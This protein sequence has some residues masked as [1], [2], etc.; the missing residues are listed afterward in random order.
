MLCCAYIDDLVVELQSSADVGN[1]ISDN[2]IVASCTTIGVSF[3]F[4]YCIIDILGRR[5]ES[6]ERAERE[7]VRV[8]TQQTCR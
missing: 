4:K 1:L 2:I 5:S 8:P 7:G 3:S 6:G